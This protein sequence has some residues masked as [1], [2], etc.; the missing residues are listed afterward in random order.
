MCIARCPCAL[1][2]A[3][4][5]VMD[6]CDVVE[7]WATLVQDPLLRS[8]PNDDAAELREDEHPGFSRI[9]DDDEEE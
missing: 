7:E 9:L 2:A 3:N 8:S 6:L 4:L 1:G 5:Q